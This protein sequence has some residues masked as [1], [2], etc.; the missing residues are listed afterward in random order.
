MTISNC[1]ETLRKSHQCA[2]I[3][4]IIAGDPDLETTAKAL[5][6]LDDTV[7][8]RSSLAFPILTRWLTGR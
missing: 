2:L 4:F 1:F 8:M 5:Q 7:Q 6:I 3:P